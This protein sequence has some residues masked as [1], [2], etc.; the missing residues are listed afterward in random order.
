MIYFTVDNSF[1]GISA[2]GA[3]QAAEAFVVI[4]QE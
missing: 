4:T 3:R 2:A 1:D